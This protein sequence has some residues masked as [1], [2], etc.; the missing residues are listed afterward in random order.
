[1][2][3][4]IRL[5]W[6]W[7]AVL[8]V[9]ALGTISCGDGSG[10]NSGGAGGT[11]ATG[12]TGGTTGTSDTLYAR[13][14]EEA[15]IKKVVDN[16]IGR[17]IADPKI[18]GYFL[19]QQVDAANLSACLVKQLGSATGGPQT[20]D[21]KDMKSAH[22]GLGISQKDFD[23][24]AGHLVDE[25]TAQKVAQDDINTIV[26]VLAPMA[27]DIVEDATNDKSIYQRAGRKPGIQTVITN[28]A[29]KVVADN[30]LN[31]FFAGADLGRIGTCLV[32]QVCEATGGPCKYGFEVD[33]GK[34]ADGKDIE[35]GVGKA[36][37][38]RDM[39]SS[40]AAINASATPITITDF[41]KLVGHVVDA[42]TEAGVQSDDITAIGAALG[43]TC[44][45]IVKD[46]VGCP[47]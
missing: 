10:T 30:T 11:T 28:F 44:K 9:A 33:A 6:T 29:G 27:T 18:N 43:P 14:G 22:A 4:R 20:Y 7:I 35:P 19:N 46:G 32:R 26:G 13:L 12:G 2:G 31:G 16:F 42:L 3:I 34:D 23:D 24:L 8:G 5:A 41:N 21:C 37:V 15:G 17:V 39:K 25:L 38:C 1:M 45:D 47:N 36:N 40:H